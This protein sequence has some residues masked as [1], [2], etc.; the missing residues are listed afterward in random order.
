M[1]KQLWLPPATLSSMEAVISLLTPATPNAQQHPGSHSLHVE[2]FVY[3][4][5][6]KWSFLSP[7][8]RPGACCLA[9]VGILSWWQKPLYNCWKVNCWQLHSAGLAPTRTQTDLILELISLINH[10][11]TL[12]RVLLTDLTIVL[13]KSQFGV[14]ANCNNVSVHNITWNTFSKLVYLKIL[15]NFEI[16]SLWPYRLSS[17]ETTASMSWPWAAV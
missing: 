1:W 10:V 6:W 8:R 17:G 13:R 5:F 4:S 15:G 2:H 11:N 9:S 3:V 7:P 16:C 14:S 12:S